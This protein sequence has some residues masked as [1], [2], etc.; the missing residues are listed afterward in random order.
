MIT[1]KLYL[2]AIMS[3]LPSSYIYG[4][5]DKKSFQALSLLEE[6]SI[7]NEVE[8]MCEEKEDGVDI[9]G[10]LAFSCLGSIRVDVMESSNNKHKGIKVSKDQILK[11]K[12]I[13]QDMK[14]GIKKMPDFLQNKI[15]IYGEEYYDKSKKSNVQVQCY[16]LYD[17][18]AHLQKYKNYEFAEKDFKGQYLED[19]VMVMNAHYTSNNE[20]LKDIKNNDVRKAHE[21][22]LGQCAKYLPASGDKN[23]KNE[24]L[25]NLLISQELHSLQIS[26]GQN[27]NTPL[28]D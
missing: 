3:V 1:Y 2:L 15:D 6:P 7:D 20:F 22:L 25:E 21:E 13:L 14:I 16:Q 18:V 4:A 12:G 27:T 10:M 17:I 11:V 26:S 5:A 28:I 8:V 9:A 24:E 19:L 23:F